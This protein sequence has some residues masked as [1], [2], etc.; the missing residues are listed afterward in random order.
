MNTVSLTG[1]RRFL[2]ACGLLAIS[3]FVPQPVAALDDYCSQWCWE[4]CVG[5]CALQNR[6]CAAAAGCNNGSYCSCWGGCY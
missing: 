1:P 4:Q 5:F 6:I 3:F 2:L